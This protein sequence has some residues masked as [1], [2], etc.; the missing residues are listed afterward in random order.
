MADGPGPHLTKIPGSAHDVHEP[1]VTYVNLR[2]V[3]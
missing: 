1:S 3:R 2:F